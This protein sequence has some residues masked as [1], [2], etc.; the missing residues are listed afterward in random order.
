VSGST[1]T[2]NVA[3]TPATGT[4][5]ALP[6]LVTGGAT[7]TAATATG[8]G[9]AKVPTV[10]DGTIPEADITLTGHLVPFNWTGKLLSP[11]WTGQLIQF[12]WTGKLEE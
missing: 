4:G 5:T 6:P 10:R 2:T 1:A 12:N 7:I 3:A 11:T 8:S 9:Q